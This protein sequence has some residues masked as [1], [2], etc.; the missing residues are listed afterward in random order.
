LSSYNYSLFLIKHRYAYGEEIRN[1]ATL[2]AEKWKIASSSVL[3]TKAEKLVWDGE[4][5]EVAASADWQRERHKNFHQH[6]T[7]TKQPTVDLVDDQWTHAVG[8][9]PLSGNADPASP[10]SMEEL[11]AYMKRLHAIDLPR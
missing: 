3:Q 7:T 6:F 1:Y 4:T 8:L 5:K 9:V 2:I 11:P 10:K